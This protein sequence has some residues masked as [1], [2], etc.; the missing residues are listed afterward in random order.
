MK[1]FFIIAGCNGCGKTT[2]Y[3]SSFIPK[4]I[5]FVNFDNIARDELDIK[6]QYKQEISF[7]NFIKTGKIVMSRIA[8][9]IERNISFVIEVTSISSTLINYINEANQRGYQILVFFVSVESYETAYRRVLL[10]SEAGGHYVSKDIVK[11]RY[12]R[13]FDTLI[14]SMNIIDYTFFFDNTDTL[15]IFSVYNKKKPLYVLSEKPS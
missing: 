6:N 9:S 7:K 8:N 1:Q 2:L 14:K 12:E 5:P 13:C 10:R 15:K 4:D 11:S 3:K